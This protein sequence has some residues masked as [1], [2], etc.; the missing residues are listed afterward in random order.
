MTFKNSSWIAWP[1]NNYKITAFLTALLLAFGLWAIYV[2]PKDEFPPF[3]IRQGVVIAVMPGATAEEIEEQVARPLERYIFTYKEVDR[4]KTYS[5]S[6]NGMCIVMVQFQQDQNNLTPVWSKMKHGLNQFKSSLP[7][8]VLALVA[9][10]D[11]G[12]TSA[13]LITVESDQRSYRELQGYSDELADRLRRLPSVSNVRQIGEKKEQLTITVDKERLAAYGIGRQA[14]VQALT[15]QGLTTM[16]GMVSTPHQNLKIHVA[17]SISSEQEIGER[18]IFNAPDGKVLRVRDIATVTREYDMSEAYIESNGKRCVILSL[19]M[20]K[21]NNIVM[22]GEDVD[23]ILNQFREDCLPEDVT[24]RRITDQPLVVGTSVS[25]FLRDLIISMLIIVAVMIVLFP[26]KS[27]IVAALTIPLS[28]FVST[29]IMYALGIEL[30]IITLAC[31][32]VVLG[33]IVD[34]SIVVIDGYL[35]YLGKG[36]GRREAAVKSVQ[37]YFWPMLLA[38]VCICA[39]FFPILKFMKGEAADVIKLFPL[40]ITINLMVSLVVAAFIIPLLNAAIIRRVKAK[41]P[42]K[43]DITDWVQHWYDKTLEWNFRHP[44]LTIVGS[45]VLVVATGALFPLLKMRQFP[46][47][48]RNQFAVEVYLPEGSGLE[49]TRLIADE[50]SAILKSN[51]K[52]TGVT[53]FV[54]CSSPRFHTSY[55][56][57]IAGKNFAQLI[58]NTESNEASL[59]L[60]D[61]LAPKYSNHWPNAYVRWKQMDY[62]P[63]PTYEYRFYGNNTDSIQKAAQMLMEEMRRIPELEWV[64]TDF[65]MPSPM[66]QVSLDP[67]ASAQMGI[68]RTSA[69]LQLM[70]QTGKVQVG[71][72]WEAGNVD[73]K[74]RTYEVPI[75]M[76]DRQQDAMQLSDVENTYLTTPTASSVALRQVAEVKPVW[77]QTKIVHRNGERCIS[78]TAEGKRGTFALDIQNHLIDYIDHMNLPQGVRAEVGGETEKNNEITP[79]VMVSMGLAVVLIFFFLLFNFRKFSIATVCIVAIS[80]GM[81]GA[82]IGLL[83]ANKVLGLTGMFGFITLMGMIMRNEILIFEH[84]NEKMSEGMSAR[85]AALDA[86]KRRMVPIFLTTATTAVGVVPMI[87]AGSSFWMP[88]GITIFAGGIGMLLLVTTVLPVVYWKLYETKRKTENGKRKTAREPGAMSGNSENSDYSEHSESVVTTPLPHREGRGGS[89]GSILLL[90]FLPLMAQAQPRTVSLQEC[91]QSAATQNRTLLNATLQIQMAGEQKREA[92]TKYFPEISAN[93]LAFH[94]FD[95]MVKQDGY[96]PQELAAL[97]QINPAFAALAGQPYSI[98]ELDK[99]YAAM[100]TLTQPLFVGGQI[101]NGNRLADIGK[102]VAELQAELQTKDL[103]QK[104]T[105]NYYQ[106]VKLKLNLATIRSAQEQLHAIYREVQSYVD[107]GVTTRNDLLRVRLELQRLSSD[108]LTVGNAHHVMCLLLAQQTGMAGEKI[109]VQD[110][111]LADIESPLN[112]YISPDEAVAARQELALAQKGVEAGKL[113]VR[114]ERGKHLPTVAVGLTVSNV[115]LGGL[116]EGAKSMMETNITNGMV[117]GTVSVPITSWWGGSHAIRREKLALQ[118]SQNQLQ[119]AREQLIIDIESSWSSLMEAYKQI[120]I[121]RTSVAEATENMRM[122]MDKYRSGTEILS[123]LLESQT[124]LR[125]SMSRLASAQ[126]TYMTKRADYLRKTR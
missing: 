91:L 30:N 56:P 83:I 51:D 43:R 84:A 74:S 78:V 37:Q 11:F 21:G 66:V 32:I 65:D 77:S 123:T 38:T 12:D 95:K 68:T 89:A 4:S 100:A 117:F 1:I 41:E 98:R 62:L 88:V 79:D 23:E 17:P 45:I 36:M 85:E 115:G 33:M 44:W 101:V 58:V 5:T 8:G 110:M 122:S 104:V 22:F 53:S 92:F 114:M 124:L 50:L 42:G 119:D 121:A 86:G 70:L 93:L 39:I 57:V 64:H 80:L 46:F 63:V 40:T 60:L 54:G 18:I 126:A 26:L 28:T 113:K 15:S 2:M 103:L 118:Q 29:G 99:G 61:Q 3:T 71:S 10:D 48:D 81:P 96:Y 116:S 108:S 107:A 102:Q 25:D 55:A 13:L 19:E 73:G 34:N 112:Y 59:E 76:K 7:Q 31:L 67:V 16:S 97:G 111:A 35:E 20:L 120:D 75:V 27:A 87:L 90:L 14:L 52:V 49:E 69:E 109:D 72:I 94:A 106:I 24:M 105:E 82:I 47:A 9:Q 125:E 6:Q